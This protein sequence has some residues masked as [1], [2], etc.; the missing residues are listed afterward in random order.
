MDE[1]KLSTTHCSEICFSGVWFQMLTFLHHEESHMNSRGRA[2][3]NKNCRGAR[4]QRT[5]KVCHSQCKGFLLRYFFK[6]I[7][8]NF[9]A[10]EMHF[11]TELIGARPVVIAYKMAELFRFFHLQTKRIPTIV[12]WLC[13]KC[14]IP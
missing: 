1:R 14:H 2:E 8:T 12:P 9:I 3:A 6:L 7:H 13:N 5:R 4:M 10:S 11:H